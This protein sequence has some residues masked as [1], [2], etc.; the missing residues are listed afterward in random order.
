M[1]TRLY[2]C[3][4]CNHEYET[5]QPMHEEL[6]TLC[7][8][9]GG[10]LYQDLTGVFTSIKQ[11]NTVGSQAEKNTKMLGH[12]GRE[13]KERQLAEENKMFI[14][15][16]NRQIESTTGIKLF[17]TDPEE[18]KKIGQAPPKVINKMENGDKAGVEKYIYTGEA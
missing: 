2:F 5:V 3:K 10:K 1:V 16:R 7:P 9:C 8:K 11:Y 6:H 17:K 13:E 18:A 4:D 14:E 12:Y 15:E